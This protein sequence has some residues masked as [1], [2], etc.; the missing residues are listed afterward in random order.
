MNVAT[1]NL[2]R[3]DSRH[4]ALRW[5]LTQMVVG[6]GG[7]GVVYTLSGWLSALPGRDV[8]VL[9]P[10]VLDHLV[11]FLPA[12]VWWYLSFF[13]LIPWACLAAPATRI[14]GLRR[15]MHLCALVCGIV[16]VLWPTTLAIG[17]HATASLSGRVLAWVADIDTLSNCLPSLHGALTTLA[18]LALLDR[19]RPWRTMLALAWGACVAVSVLL[20]RQHTVL[21]LV[22]GMVVGASCGWLVWHHDWRRKVRGGVA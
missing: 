4:H 16:F 7:V 20:V 14:V 9:H 18:V 12:G 21:D 6:W 11:P 5:R 1:G 8:T 13:L 22:T 17:P 10:G 15:A 3:I 2:S 19:Q